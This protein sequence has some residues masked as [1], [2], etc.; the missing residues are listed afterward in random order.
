MGWNALRHRIFV[1][2]RLRFSGGSML[3]RTG[4]T[5]FDRLAAMLV[6]FDLS[7]APFRR[8]AFDYAVFSSINLR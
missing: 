7:T 5:H 6:S 1:G 4:E 8:C 3:Y 2:D